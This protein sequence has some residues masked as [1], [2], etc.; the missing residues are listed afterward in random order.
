LN[1]GSAGSLAVSGPNAV[2]GSGVANG[3]FDSFIRFNTA[4]MVASFNTLYGANNWVIDGANLRV[5]ETGAPAN[6]L[7]NRGVGAF[8]IRW[9][10]NDAWT[11]GTGTPVT[12]TTNGISYNNEAAL[13]NSGTDVSLGIFTNAGIDRTLNFPLALAPA[14]VNDLRAGGE[15][16]FYLTAVD[17]G[18]GFTMDSRN[19]VTNSLR[20]VLELSAVPRPGIVGIQLSGTDVLL[21]ATNGAAGTAYYVLASTN[22]TLPLNQWLSVATNVLSASGNFSFTLTNAAS[23]EAPARQ[24][25]ILSAH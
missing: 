17:P 25:F 7:F 18:I 13:L 14:L 19:F 5:F 12:P 9:I 21:T 3:V 8:E 10:A 2:N 16:G 24:Y 20:P 22:L 6:S 11:E 15:V 1:Y 23:A 4:A